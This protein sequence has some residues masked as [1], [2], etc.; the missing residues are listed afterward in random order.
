[1]TEIRFTADL[2]A[3]VRV[4]LQGATAR[5][6]RTALFRALRE[7]GALGWRAV[8]IPAGG[9]RLPLANEPDFDWRL[10]GARRGRGTVEGEERE[11][12]WYDGQF[13]SRR[14]FEANPRRKL[15]PAVKYSRV[16]KNGDALEAVEEADGGF[17]Y[18]TLAVFRGE[19]RRREAYAIPREESET[20]ETRAERGAPR[21]QTRLE[22]SRR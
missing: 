12:V 2:G 4:P 10:V 6:V 5:E 17:S 11:G 7:Y 21:V 9:L 19:G 8:P 13:F 3:E 20:G 15:G 18:V 1:M 16:A 22:H 14:K